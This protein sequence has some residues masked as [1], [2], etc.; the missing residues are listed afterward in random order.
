MCTKRFAAGA[1]CSGLLVLGAAWAQDYPNRP[2]R[3]YA[4][5]AGGT[6]DWMA[7]VMAK[8]LTG[9]LGQPVIVDNRPGNVIP[10]EIVSKAPPD[11]YSVLSHGQA[12]AVGA[13]LQKMRYDPL[14]DFAPISMTASAP[15]VVVVHPSLPVK[16]IKELIALA[17]AKP[18][19]LNYAS[20]GMGA[21]PHLAAELFKNMTKVDI[22]HIP[23]KGAGAAMVDMI[24]GQVQVL[25]SVPNSAV[26]HMK[27]GRLRAIAVTSAKPSALFPGLPTV[28]AS[29]VPGY[30]AAGLY[31]LFAPAKTPDAIMRRLYQESVKFLATDEAKKIF[32]DAG[33]ETVGSTGEQYAAVLKAEMQR[34]SQVI[35]AA[36]IRLD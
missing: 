24:S 29:G 13:L 21:T 18:G 36:N 20:T 15:L 5:A 10:A 32:L 26:P 34:M 27:S 8:G 17:R 28:A 25:F 11:G 12:L 1:L 16:S 22:T 3:I 9:P 6:F 14:A 7:R 31:G 23:Y 33:M 2:V 35:K 30:E 4:N 19:E